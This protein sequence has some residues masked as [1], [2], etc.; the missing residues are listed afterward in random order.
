MHLIPSPEPL[1]NLFLAR[2][3]A[4]PDRVQSYSK[5]EGRWVATTWREGRQAVEETALGLLTMGVSTRDRIA[6][7]SQTRREWAQFDMACLCLGGVTVG[8]YPS[9]P[10]AQVRQ[11]LELSGARVVFVDDRA[12]RVKVQ[13]STAGLQ[14]PVQIVTL[15]PKAEGEAVVTLDELRR[16]GAKHRRDHPEEFVRRAREVKSSDVASY[17]YTSGTTGEPKGAMLTHANFHYVVHATN[18]VMSYD[19]ERALVFLPLAHSLQR[20]ASYLGL[21]VDIEG[22][23]AE[24]FDK[25]QDNLLEVRPTVFA[26]VPRVLEKV[27]A[28]VLAWGAESPGVK[29]QLFERAMGTLQELGRV[30]RDGGVPGLRLRVKARAADQMVGARV[31]DLLG[32]RVKFIGSGGAPLQRSTH[33]FFE[34]MGIPILEGYGL[35][36]TS[37]PAC[38][39]TLDNRRMGTVGR[40]LPG[41]DVRIAHDG[42]IL[43]KGPG[44]FL[45]YYGNASATEA[46]FE[47]DVWFKSG[48]VG[49]MSRDG[50]L[51]IT[52]RKKNLIVT[53]SGK[54][55]APS[56]IEGQ[57]KRHALVAQAVVVGDR[58]PYLSALLTLDAQTRQGVAQ[59]HG[60]DPSDA[61]QLA[62]LPA[63]RAQL[64]QHVAM[65][66][67]G[68]PSHEQIKRFEVLPEELTIESGLLTPTLKVKRAR[69]CDQFSAHIDRLYSA[70]E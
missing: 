33:E 19:R 26:L 63:V 54:N 8:I 2:A 4:A 25:V 20:Y 12:Q 38:V 51:T 47:D 44:V 56:P 11:L 6:I 27:H 58:K 55:I 13:E 61:E 21:T 68:R 65:I 45:G 66:N 59:T 29:Q 64:E 57:L 37:A 5:V 70:P 48:D 9:L 60:I 42:E 32:G 67:S 14:P 3:E 1:P 7:L 52:D 17:I 31:R 39:N 18:S 40:P 22:Y 41:T 53:A 49:R 23:Y 50:F 30:H 24:S 43:I 69:V 28:K 46:A 62:A 36:E 10:G 16:R 15:E 34:D 35:T